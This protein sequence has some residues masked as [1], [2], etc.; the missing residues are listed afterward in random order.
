MAHEDG[1]PNLMRWLPLLWSALFGMALLIC[2]GAALTYHPE[3]LAGAS[4]ALFA[5]LVTCSFAAYLLVTWGWN[6]NGGPLPTRRGVPY[7]LVQT[8]LLVA[9]ITQFDRAFIWIT[10]PLLYQALGALER[11]HWPIP[12][13]CLLGLAVIALSW[14]GN[15]SNLGVWEVIGLG[16][17]ALSNASMALLLRA[18]FIQR[19]QL[20]STVA[21]LHVAQAQLAASAAQQEELAVLR[22]RT[23]LARALHDSIGHAL[24]VMNVKLEAAQ[25]LYAHDRARGDAELEQSR[26]LIRETMVELRSSLAGMRAAAPSDLAGALARLSTNMAERAGIRLECRVQLGGA[27]PPPEIGEALWYIAREA[28][29]NVE[30]HAG[31]A[32]ASLALSQA[33]GGWRL[34]VADDGGSIRAADLSQPDHYGVTGMRERAEALGG[35]LDLRRSPQGGTLVAVWLPACAPA[36]SQRL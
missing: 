12:L 18:L 19:H 5:A 32:H 8:A 23:R 26:V 24:V 36:P 15:L 4:G 3:R 27:A 28:L 9:L 2:A 22:E 34:E 16:M 20:R 6:G 7:F 35:T 17:F 14:D 10:I 11:R 31:A 1:S 30:K 25:M 29:T 21:E 13:A 33:E